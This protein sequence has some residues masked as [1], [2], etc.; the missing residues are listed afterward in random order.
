MPSQSEAVTHPANL[1]IPLGAR[2][3]AGERPLSGH[4][5][6][7]SELAPGITVVT[8]Y[9]SR[10]VVMVRIKGD[11]REIYGFGESWEAAVVHLLRAYQEQELTEGMMT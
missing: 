2:L 5:D 3:N 7:E 1:G 8:R 9:L 11:V 4:Q 10:D 6:T